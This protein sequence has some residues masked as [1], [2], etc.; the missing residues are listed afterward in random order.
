MLLLAQ[1]RA[2]PC[3]QLQ[4]LF[5]AVLLLL[6]PLLL[7][8]LFHTLLLLALLLPWMVQGDQL[9]LHLLL[10]QQQQQQGLQL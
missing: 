2:A 1:A 10:P 7:R 4:A 5:P 9:A 6:L 3:C 8:P